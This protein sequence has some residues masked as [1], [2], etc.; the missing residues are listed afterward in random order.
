MLYLKDIRKDYETSSE[1]VHALKG[2]SIAFRKNEFVSILGPSGCGKT[3]LLN[4][5]GGLDHYTDGD[6]FINGR[7]TK[8]YTDRDWDVYRNHRVGFIFQSYN[9]IPHQT[10]LG[11]VELALTIAGIEKEERIRRAK[12]AL[13]RV[14]LADQ[15][16]KRPN[17]L[18]GGQCQRVAIARAL[19]NDPEILLA[20]EPTGAL[21]T[22]TSVQIMELIK[23][24]S[25]ERLVIMVTHNPELAD[26]YSSRIIRLLDGCVLEDSNP[27]SAEEEKAE[28]EVAVKAEAEAEETEARESAASG[29]K[30]KKPKEKAKM[31]FFT[32]FKLSA[33]NLLSKKG[34]TAMVG[35]A[36]SIGIIG[37][38]LVLAF[39][40]GIKGYIASMQN[41]MLSGNPITV[42]ETA[43]DLSALTG[44]MNS[45]VEDA[46]EKI[47]GNIYVSSLVEYLIKTSDMLNSMMV[48]NEITE[49]YVK[50]IE[51]MPRDNVNAVMF[52]YGI[53]L[54]HKLFVDFK[55][56]ADSEAQ[57][58]SMKHLTDIYTSVLKDTDYEDLAGM[59]SYMAPNFSQAVPDE[60]YIRSQYD[61]IA[62]SKIAAEANE[63][64]I[65]LNSEDELSDLLLAR[66]GYFTEAEFLEIINK[67]SAPTKDENGN[68]IEPVYNKA[69]YKDYFTYEEILGKTF[70][71]YPNDTLFEASDGMFPGSVTVKYN[72]TLEKGSK[73]GLTLNIVGI[74]TPKEGLNYG[75]LSS[76]IYY[77]EKLAEQIIE[78]ERESEFVNFLKEKVEASENEI[79]LMGSYAY[80]YFPHTSFN[81]DGKIAGEVKEVNDG[82]IF[83]IT[84]TASSV[85]RSLGGND[86][87]NK[88]SI[89]P[90]SFEEKTAITEYLEAWNDDKT[91]LVI[92][93]KEISGA[94]RKNVK[95]TDTIELVANIINTMIDVITYALV[96]FTSVSLIVS[97]VM[98]GIITYV[99]VVERIKEIGVIRSLG[100]RKKDVSHLFNAETFIIGLLAGLIGILA[101]YAIS[102]VVNLILKPL[103]NY[104]SI[105]AL[106]LSQAVILVAISIGLTLISGLIPASSAAKK[107]PVVALRTE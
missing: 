29:K 102:F 65:V 45:E 48:T 71:V 13:D 77:T 64:M 14:G 17:Q 61:I 3:T 90:K 7:S 60:D 18:S 75:S 46:I 41:D 68:P 47:P 15:Y 107:D 36:G 63:I 92:D 74:L 19:V 84:A 44:M 30:E 99:S 91:T 55:T 57:H 106:P 6:L 16:Y 105:A 98:I 97:T 76:G 81:S 9:L 83:A 28:T 87:V 86:L 89:Y 21:D 72:S 56:D 88:I 10:V 39:S 50:Y 11:N 8:D 27:F 59:V 79:R 4:I 96:A 66:L 25:R 5:I 34:R 43:L 73:E 85:I 35:F 69:L 32:A 33:K 58:V 26:Q 51:N 101:T 42:S 62:G 12:E 67:A 100:G 2:V 53:D 52:E 54:T 40:A 70:T 94:E 20:D 78:S 37:I 38:A 23:E 104:A 24:I 80:S 103:I 49:D 82:S 93:G 1:V 31:S 22:V 95:H